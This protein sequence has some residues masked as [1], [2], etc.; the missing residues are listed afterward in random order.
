MPMGPAGMRRGNIHD[1]RENTR[2]AKSSTDNLPSS[3]RAPGRD[4]LRMSHL[5]P[6]TVLAGFKF[7]GNSRGPVMNLAGPG[8]HSY[9]NPGSKMY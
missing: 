8:G 4:N 2:L 1:K 6:K 9:H 5:N 3:E 7:V